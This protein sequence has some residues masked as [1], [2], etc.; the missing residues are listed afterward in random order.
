MAEDQTLLRQYLL[1][2][3]SQEAQHSIEERLFARDEYL[4][5]MLIAE[6][7][8]IDSYLGG[9]LSGREVEDF[10]RH[11]LFTPERRLKLRFALS[12]RKYVSASQ[13]E[14]PPEPAARSATELAGR[15]SWL[16]AFLHHLRPAGYAP[17]LASAL[18][19]LVA[20]GSWSL[21][22]FRQQR[23]QRAELEAEIV[24][25]NRQPAQGAEVASAPTQP[26]VA[27]LILTQGL[28]RSGG[29][30]RQVALDEN[31]RSVHLRCDLP[32]DDFPNYQAVLQLDGDE[33]P[34]N[35]GGLRSR[36]EGDARVLVLNLPAKLL[37]DGDYLL[38]LKG[39]RE[40]GGRAEDVATYRFRVT[41]KVSP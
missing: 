32:A 38:L 17:L 22:T 6:D 35:V 15:R 25:L 36:A 2:E 3:L 29:D 14:T 41:S 18:V 20:Y 26:G 24:E 39:V 21:I 23:Q 27:A 11:F 5:E 7:E 19:L 34:I 30:L 37:A 9:S 16:P 4:D 10:K 12:L 28:V 31:A 1:G 40:D 8:L 13:A 33:R